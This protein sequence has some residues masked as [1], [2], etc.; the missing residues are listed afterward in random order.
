MAGVRGFDLC[1]EHYD[2]LKRRL[3]RIMRAQD[4]A[5]YFLMLVDDEAG[6]SLSNLKLQ[7]LVCY[8]QGFQLA[9][10]GRTLFEEPIEAWEQGPVVP[11]LYHRFKQYGSGPIPPP[12]EGIDLDAYPEDVRELLDEVFQVYGQYSAW[13][14]RN[15]THAESP[16]IEAHSQ[17]PST[18]IS[19]D[20][21]KSYFS[22]LVNA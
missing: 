9:L 14:L 22:T 11:S 3:S 4:V 10:T 8:A 12:A 19:H 1:C 7:K 6:D 13:K 18:V 21:M 5:N 17:S 2:K 15:M 20:S 16:W